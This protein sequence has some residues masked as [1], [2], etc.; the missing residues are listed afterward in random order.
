MDWQ[1]LPEI[2]N[3]FVLKIAAPTWDIKKAASRVITNSDI[4]YYYN[5]NFEK[6]AIFAIIPARNSDLF[7]VKAAA[8]RAVGKSNVRSSFLDI[9][10]L[11][12]PYAGWIKVAYSP[13]LRRMGEYLNFF[14]GQYPGGIPNHPSP[15]AAMLSSGLVGAGLG[16]GAG[17]LLGK[18]LP[19]GYGNKL[20]R[21]GLILG[22]ALGSVPGA[23]W[24]LTNKGI[25]K[26]FNDPSIFNVRPDEEPQNYPD[27]INGMNRNIPE[28]VQESDNEIGNYLQE[29]SHHFH[30]HSIDEMLKEVKLGI[31]YKQACI[32]TAQ[33]STFGDIPVAR[34]PT[35]FDVNINALG[36]T[37]YKQD[38]SPNLAA[39]TMSAM[40]AAQQLPDSRASPN[41][42]TF[43]QLGQLAQNAAGDYAKGILVGAAINSVIGTPFRASTFGLANTG[44]GI[45]GAVIPKLFG[46]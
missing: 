40:Y 10:E 1:D 45:I 37:L 36:Q 21:T 42:A 35:P 33:A 5:P 20:G 26:D 2:I 4:G 38:A 46:Q 24:G 7:R 14:P 30:K 9:K 44:L 8:E 19:E 11:S 41:W 29:M 13:T 18:L 3:D 28:P 6:V 16:W 32:K 15:I 39:T 31:L 17:T 27:F 23:I 22:G 12:N 25:G 34:E 43:G